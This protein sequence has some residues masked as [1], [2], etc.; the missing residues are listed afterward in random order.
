MSDMEHP[1]TVLPSKLGENEPNTGD[2][3]HRNVNV[4]IVGTGMFVD[5]LQFVLSEH[6]MVSTN[7]GDLISSAISEAVVADADVYLV[8]RLEPEDGIP[9]DNLRKLAAVGRGVVVLSDIISTE[10]AIEAGVSMLPRDVK[11]DGIIVGIRRAFEGEVVV[12]KPEKD[13]TAPTADAE[14]MR[15][16]ELASYLTP[17]ETECLWM[18]YDGKKTIEM[19]ETMD[20]TASTVSTYV[21]NLHFKLNTHSRLEIAALAAKY[22]IK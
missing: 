9:A 11:I 7:V 16:R 15:A 13:T 10:E 4:G 3:S 1:P 22:L 2:D 8:T 19:A 20:V 17:R 5:S 12:A 6:G 14:T 21:K 18:I